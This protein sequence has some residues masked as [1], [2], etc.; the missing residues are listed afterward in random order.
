M[1]GMQLMKVVNHDAGTEDVFADFEVVPL[2]YDV[3]KQTKGS[4]PDKLAIPLQVLNARRLS[5]DGTQVEAPRVDV[6]V[7]FTTDFTLE[8]RALVMGGWLPPGLVPAHSVLLVD[9]CA[10]SFIRGR[11]ADGQLSQPNASPDFVDLLG[12]RVNRVS[13]SPLLMEGK[14]RG[15]KSTSSELA[16]IYDEAAEAL[17]RAMPKIEIVGNKAGAVRA[18]VAIIE[19][20]DALRRREISFL[21]AIAPMVV[22]RPAAEKLL[23]RWNV[24]VQ[25]AR[26]RQLHLGSP[27][28]L[29]ALSALVAAPGNPAQKILKPR[30]SYSDAHAHN[31]LSDLN[32]L[33]YLLALHGDF[34]GEMPVFLTWDKNLALFWAG[35]GTQSASRDGELLHYHLNPHH[36]LFPDEFGAMLVQ[37]AAGTG[38]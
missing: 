32:A 17:H 3:L 35:L 37:Q 19:Q 23:A 25:E 38:K 30:H 27:P 20:E 33:R 21:K 15:G 6:T 34:P 8:L 4:V 29:A 14:K 18:A 22:S 2:G 31:A 13:F 11:F 16:Q 10:L 1:P 9:S 5:G 7:P 24:I 26:D 12:D 36:E 28:V